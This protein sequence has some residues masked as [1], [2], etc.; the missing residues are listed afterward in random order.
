[1]KRSV[2][3]GQ[4]AIGIIGVL[5]TLTCIGAI[6]LAAA[7][8]AGVGVSAAIARMGLRLCQVESPLTETSST[9]W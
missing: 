9:W 7:G 2:D 8:V 3:I 1:M 4:A 5:G 6:V